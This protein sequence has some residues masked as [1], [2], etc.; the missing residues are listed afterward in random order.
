MGMD[1]LIACSLYIDTAALSLI[2]VPLR[3]ALTRYHDE[4]GKHED[5]TLREELTCLFIN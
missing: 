3:A 1:F 5:I 2:L 4:M